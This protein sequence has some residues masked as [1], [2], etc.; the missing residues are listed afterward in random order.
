MRSSLSS[1][2]RLASR[3]C[4]PATVTACESR[5]EKS[6]G[7]ILSGASANTQDGARLDVAADF[8]GSR[9]ERAFFDV[10]VFNLY[11]PSNRQPQLV[12]CKTPLVSATSNVCNE[13]TSQTACKRNRTWIVYAFG[14]LCY[15]RYWSGPSYC[16]QE[17]SFNAGRET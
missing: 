15:W 17:T 12:S 13:L 14:F 8:G 6:T 3:Y 5:E 7:E 11:T 1:G 4:S 9:F 10:R 16:L 2:R